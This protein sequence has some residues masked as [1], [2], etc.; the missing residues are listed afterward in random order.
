MIPCRKARKN[1]VAAL[2][3]NDTSNVVDK[4]RATVME[5][6]GQKENILKDELEVRRKDDVFL[7][8]IA[9][10]KQWFPDYLRR[11]PN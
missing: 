9:R 7:G 1:L 10:Y 4:L 3:N 6:V 2:L 11:R 5:L 8:L